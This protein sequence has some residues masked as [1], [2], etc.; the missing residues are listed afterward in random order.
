MHLIEKTI[1]EVKSR[2]VILSQKKIFAANKEV[3]A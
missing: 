3:S 2:K 1:T